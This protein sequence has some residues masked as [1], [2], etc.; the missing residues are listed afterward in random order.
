MD[1]ELKSYLQAMESRM[2]AMESRMGAM[3]SR[4]EAMESRLMRRINDVEERMLERFAATDKRMANYERTM[5]SV[6]ELLRNTNVLLG[7]LAST[8]VD[9]AGRVTRLENKP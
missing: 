8:V 2:G 6:V 4:M 9:V 1:D 5:D 3:E 7:S